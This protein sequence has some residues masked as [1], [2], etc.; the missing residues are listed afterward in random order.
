MHLG[1][2]SRPAAF[3][4]GQAFQGG[5]CI[6][7]MVLKLGGMQATS[8]LGRS[9]ESETQFDFLP[10]WDLNIN[11]ANPPFSSIHRGAS[12]TVNQDET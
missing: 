6:G 4:V 12:H 11:A 7:L 2:A 10:D 3:K 9:G 8:S 1:A 5:A